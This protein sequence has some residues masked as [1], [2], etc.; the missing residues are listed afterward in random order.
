MLITN[1][2]RLGDFFVILSFVPKIVPK[3]LSN[4]IQEAKQPKRNFIT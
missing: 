4:L 2:S 3:I 1:A